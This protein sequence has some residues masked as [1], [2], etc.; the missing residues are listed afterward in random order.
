M[1]KSFTVDSIGTEDKYLMAENILLL[2]FYNYLDIEIYNGPPETI[3]IPYTKPVLSGNEHSIIKALEAC[4]PLMLFK[5][6]YNPSDNVILLYL[7]KY[8]YTCLKYI[9]INRKPSKYLVQNAILINGQN[10]KDYKDMFSEQE[11]IKFLEH[12]PHILQSIDNPTYEMYKIAMSKRGRLITHVANQTLELCKL[13]IK[14]IIEEK[15]TYFNHC[16]FLKHIKFW[17][18]EMSDMIVND[19]RFCDNLDIIPNLS[20]EKIEK[21]ILINPMRL[22]CFSNII[23]SEEIYVKAYNINFECIKFIPENCQT[24]D[25]CND[26]RNKYLIYIQYSR[27]K[28]I[29]DFNKLISQNY[30]NIQ[31]I[32]ENYQTIEMCK[33]VVNQNYSYLN[34]CYCIDKEMLFNIFKSKYMKETPKKERFDFI[35][36][37]DEAALIRIIKVDTRLLR[38][39]PENKQTDNLIKEILKQDGYAL[40]YVI[41]PT[42]EHFDIA[43]QNQPNAI[44]YV[45]SSGK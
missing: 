15:G 29:D 16:D 11:I 7:R 1:I 28:N 18:D 10:F 34:Y 17:D 12:N 13:A 35:I 25:I 32:P 5:Y 30:K 3:E 22:K 19:R 41:S 2:E 43:L 14:N 24:D 36:G 40:Q 9:K 6:I 39:L 20:I 33:L 23:F 27:D 42:Q 38:T 37:Y 44:K 8:T 26:I 31:F 45:K 4:G 21:A